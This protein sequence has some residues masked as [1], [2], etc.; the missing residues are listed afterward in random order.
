[1][2]AFALHRVED[3][4]GF[5]G[6]GIVADGIEFPDGTTVI[7]WRGDHQSTVIWED[8]RTAQAVHGHDG[9]TRFIDVATGREVGD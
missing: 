7:R 4:T 2:R 3:V 5:S 9:K 8:I 6:T 1:M